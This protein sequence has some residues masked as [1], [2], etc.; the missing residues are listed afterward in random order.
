MK[1]S[2][3]S[4]PADQQHQTVTVVQ[5][6]VTVNATREPDSPACYF[7]DLSMPGWPSHELVDVPLERIKALG[8]ALISLHHKLTDPSSSQ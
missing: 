6:H 5:G 2:Q 1:K 8:E 3:A 7:L 4:M